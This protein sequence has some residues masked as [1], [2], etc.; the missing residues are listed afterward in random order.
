MKIKRE[1]DQMGRI[2]KCTPCQTLEA[3]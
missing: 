2:E 3:L 1:F